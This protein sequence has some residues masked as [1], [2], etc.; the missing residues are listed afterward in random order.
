MLISVNYWWILNL[1]FLQI[2]REKVDNFMIKTETGRIPSC[3]LTAVWTKESKPPVLVHQVTLK[4][5][6]ESSNYFSI[7]LDCD[8]IPPVTG[9][10]LSLSATLPCVCVRVCVHG[11][12]VLHYY[13]V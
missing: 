3:Q 13:I 12:T 10:L 6:K 4:G 5:A 7:V 11:C 9:K 8:T 1:M 2:T